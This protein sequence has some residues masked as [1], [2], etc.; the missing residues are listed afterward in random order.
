M[1][2][3][4]ISS[5][6]ALAATPASAEVHDTSPYGFAV[7]ATATVP[8]TPEEAWDELLDPA[9]WW[10]GNHTFSGKA[11][12]LSLDPRAGGCFCELLPGTAG[13]DAPP[14]GGVQH[15]QVAFLDKAKTL[16]LTG[17]LGPLQSEPVTGVLTFILRKEAGGTRINAEYSVGGYMRIPAERMG[18]LVDRVITEQVGRLAAKLGGAADRP[19]PPAPP[20]TPAETPAEETAPQPRIDTKPIIGR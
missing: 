17:A 8:A 14:R 13:S 16:R 19:A 20:P 4:V 2:F 1:R 11:A 9:D 10:S 7:R 12:N 18:P 15:M 6:A 5:L 3:L